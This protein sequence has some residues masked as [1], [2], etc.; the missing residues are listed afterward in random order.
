MFSGDVEGSS[1]G[2]PTPAGVSSGESEGPA[3]LSPQAANREKLSAPARSR[4]R[5]RLFMEKS[6][7][8]L[9]VTAL[10]GDI[11]K[12]FPK[13]IKVFCDRFRLYSTRIGQN[14]KRVAPCGK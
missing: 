1:D 12:R 4:E 11:G 9:I 2:V 13:N 6:S 3:P 5:M 14:C 10:D 8:L 7:F